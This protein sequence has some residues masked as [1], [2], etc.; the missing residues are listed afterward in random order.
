MNIDRG[1]NGRNARVRSL[2]TESHSD[3]VR[4]FRDWTF[5][6]LNEV[7]ER[8]AADLMSA[9]GINDADP[10]IETMRDLFEGDP[11]IATR[12][13]SWITSQRLMWRGLTDHYEQH[14][15]EYLAEF[16]RTD[17]SGPGALELD[18]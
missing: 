11:V 17:S 16:A 12:L 1:S 9:A 3:F 6:D 2:D 8:R 18:R 4:G 10:P 5:R 13:R 7:A 14:R 15:D